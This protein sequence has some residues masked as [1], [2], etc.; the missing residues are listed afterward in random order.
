MKELK[1]FAAELQIDFGVSPMDPISMNEMI[2]LR[3]AF[4]KI[5]S[6]DTNNFPM[7]ETAAESNLPLIVSTG[8]QK[9]S[10]IRRVIELLQERSV[11][12]SLLH[13]ISSYPTQ[14]Q[15]INLNQMRYL[16]EEFPNV[17]IG[18]SGHELGFNP[19]LA[20]VMLGARI[21]E[22]H[23]TLDKTM[24][25]SDHKC[26]LEPEELKKFVELVRRREKLPIFKGSEIRK[27]FNGVDFF[28]DIEDVNFGSFIQDILGSPRSELIYACEQLCQDKLGK[29]IVFASD[30]QSGTVLKMEDLAIKVSG[31]KGIAPEDFKEVVGCKLRINV[32]MD[33][34]VQREFI[35]K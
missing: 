34:A 27:F 11:D 35:T 9:Q 22:R 2:D 4:I 3:P 24:K 30:L 18:Y 17:R 16:M 32:E 7:L 23:F 33:Q 21:V 1:E 13:C 20:A 8:M 28:P 19:S 26:S 31:E 25:G 6:G 5:G 15:D 10:T 12:F 14:D 29:S